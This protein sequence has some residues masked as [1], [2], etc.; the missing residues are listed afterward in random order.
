M[1]LL[2]IKYFNYHFNLININDDSFKW[3]NNYLNNFNSNRIYNFRSVNFESMSKKMVL[4]NLNNVLITDKKGVIIKI[5]T[6]ADLEKI[7]LTD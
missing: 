2:S 7:V 3:K 1:N 5:T 4:N 6:L